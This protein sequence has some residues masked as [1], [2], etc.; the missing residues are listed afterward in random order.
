MRYTRFL[1]T[2]AALGLLA[3]TISAQAQSA[4]GFT[5]AAEIDR[6]VESFTGAP[7]GT[8]GGA[9]RPVD[10]RLRLAPCSA[11]MALGWHG[12][13]R[14]SVRVECPDAGSWR[15]FV[16]LAAQP[17]VGSPAARA[18]SV[19]AR[20]EAV[21]IVV[22]GKGFSVSQAGEA[23]EAGALG[24]WIRVRTPGASE[25]LRAQIARPGLVV[26]PL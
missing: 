12:T 9:A 20:G 23:M 1:A 26:I 6:A 15:I 25:P 17:S 4:R 3:S 5:D 22:R 19:I 13:R 11:P 8:P 18:V 14:D 24:E 2:A 21:S 7:V 10:R 16:A